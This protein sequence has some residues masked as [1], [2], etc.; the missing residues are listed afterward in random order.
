M[1][2]VLGEPRHEIYFDRVVVYFS[3]YLQ[4]SDNR[5]TVMFHVF[6]MLSYLTSAIGGGLADSRLGKYRT[7][8]YFAIVYV[9]GN[10]VMSTT[11]INGLMGKPPDSWGAITGIML[12]ALGTG[13]I[14]PCVSSFGGDQL[15]ANDPALIR[16][17]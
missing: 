15:P 5:S 17:S 13:G 10:V 7:I 12:I 4:W 16:V 1:R 8:F 6:V 9:L 3:R 2:A 14:K 11:A